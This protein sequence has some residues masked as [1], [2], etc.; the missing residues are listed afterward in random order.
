MPLVTRR[1]ISSIR[2]H[3]NGHPVNVLSLAN[4]RQFVIL[5]DYIEEAYRNGEIANA[6]FADIL[7]T[8]LLAEKGGC[9]IDSSIYM[10]GDLE[11]KV[12][13]LP[14]YSCKLEPTDFL[15]QKIY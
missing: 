7:R 11:S 8:A 4:Y 6:H 3:A 1:C 13:D 2:K 12:F 15:L 14:F 5:S 9:W 10:S